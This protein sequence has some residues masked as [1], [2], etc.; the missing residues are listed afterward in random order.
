[1]TANPNT[2]HIA[3]VGCGYWGKNLVRNFHELNALA[4]VSDGNPGVA[5][6]FG[7][8]Y[9][10]PALSWENLLADDKV[11]A[12]AIAAPAAKHASLAREALTAGKDVYVEK[13][14]AL[15]VG[16]GEEL[17]RLADEH[18]RVL[19]VGHLL[20][21]HPAFLKLRE[22]IRLGDIGRLQYVYSNRLNLG[23]FRREE[24]ILWSFAPHDISMIL[25]LCGSEPET[26]SA[27]GAYYLHR[28]VADVTTTHLDFPTGEQA[29]IFVS[30]LHP[31]KEQKLVV[32]ADDG[33]LTFDDS[34][35]WESK[36]TLYP[37]KVEWR[38][39]MPVPTKADAEPVSVEPAE[40]LRNECQHFIDCVTDRSRPRTDGREGLRVLK[41]LHRAETSLA[42]GIDGN[43][44]L[45]SSAK[46]PDEASSRFPG[47]NVH[48][49]AYV[50]DDVQIGEG[51]RI[52]HFTHVLPRTRIGRNCVLGQNVAAGPEV[53]IGDN[54]KV[55][56]NVSL[57]KG[58]VLED[59]VFCGPSCVFTN[60][61][62]PRA[63]VERKNEFLETRVKRGATIGANATIVC[64]NTI[65]AYSLI[66]AGAVVTSDVPAHALMA[67]VPARRIGWV[68]HAG[69]RLG[70][71]LICPR[72]GR[73]YREIDDNTLEE[74]AE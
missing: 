69:E 3:V 73:R 41:V 49:S 52:W 60:V 26:V 61:M 57:Y 66:A 10:V 15:K 42:Q 62:T 47:V 6:E 19:M 1:M 32:V 39:N 44:P 31:F 59:G 9:G 35:P 38:D 55:Q 68:S 43:G 18:G 50:D 2:P 72:E 4:A 29:H 37:H 16:D 12:V 58:V 22:M 7:A 51:S 65:G 74:I 17:C 48:E 21:Y 23:K 5:A 28:R 8:R 33:M 54:C 64:G 36:L 40:P 25:S 13:P 63:K 70:P 20:Q 27:V 34:Q 11:D 45:T 46:A 71:D 24:N 56:N 67:G 14:L 30:W 53:V